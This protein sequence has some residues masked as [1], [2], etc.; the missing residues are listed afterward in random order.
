M[1]DVYE[2]AQ[3]Y[4]QMSRDVIYPVSFQKPRKEQFQSNA[5]FG[6]GT[7]S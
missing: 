2:I 1:N 4:E 3:K 6:M 5:E 7:W